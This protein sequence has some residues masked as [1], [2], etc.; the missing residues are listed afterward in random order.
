MSEV[1]VWP[2]AVERVAAFLRTAGAE[3]RVEEFAAGTATARDAAKALG[4]ALGQI[5][6]TL[7]FACDERA[8]AVL[9]PGDRRADAGKVAAA[10]RA[11]RASIASPE[12]VAELTG[13]APGAVAPFSLD[14][15]DLLLLEQTLLLH[16]VVWV[17]AGSPNHLAAIPPAE[18]VRLTRAQV[19]DVVLDG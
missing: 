9:V 3:A 12:R 1:G 18:L 15:L 2:E 19:V 10:V 14:R 4:S 6:K 17:G 13:F 7:V 5:V 11:E 16:P 8:V